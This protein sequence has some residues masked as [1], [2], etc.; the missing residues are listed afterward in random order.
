VKPKKD[1]IQT[2]AVFH[3]TRFFMLLLFFLFFA[4]FIVIRVSSSF[5]MES[6]T[7]LFGAKYSLFNLVSA[8]AFI[9]LSL[10]AGKRQLNMALFWIFQ[11]IFFGIGGLM[12]QL[13]PFPYYLSQTS[14]I[15]YLSKAAQITL[16]AQIAVGIAQIFVISRNRKRISLIENHI[17]RDVPFIF[18]RVKYSLFVY[19][20]ISPILIS[21]LGGFDFLFRRIR[22][23]SEIQFQ[24]NSLSAILQTLLYVP[25]LVFL[26]ILLYF[27]SHQRIRKQTLVL[28]SFW[29]LLLSNP[30]GNARQLTL[31]L[32]LPLIYVFLQNRV[33]STLL[34]FTGLPFLLLF[35]AGLVNRYTG[36]L[37]LPKLT[38]I[39]RDGDFDSFA[40]VSNGL[41]LV[42]QGEF[43]LLRQIF[44][45]VLFFVPRSFF[46]NKPS[47]TGVEL[48][49]ALGLRFQNL[50]APWILEAYANARLV[51]VVLVGLT[52]GFTLT[53]ID[54]KSSSDL[55]GYLL[56]ALTSGFLFILLRGSL[57][58]AT[59]RIVF[60]LFLVFLIL[61]K[62]K[63]LS[64]T[65]SQ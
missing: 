62:P 40:Q 41:L 6:K 39:S 5:E 30:L 45:S 21:G 60:T 24:V 52:L 13:D 16:V 8:A 25:P 14:S 59:G 57:L 58:Q 54:L 12:T 33:K 49:R 31:F 43:P 38:V 28:L 18:K 11:F 51:G 20:L 55:K 27:R 22:Q 37:Q 15:Y 4:L 3:S 61:R 64:F 17:S 1:I 2:S 50:S 10:S 47:D 56:G 34:F 32:T 65:A 44:G 53:K 42:S 9:G 36:Q 23:N 7:S 19:F 63:N 29:I 46:P 26:L 48:A 35:G